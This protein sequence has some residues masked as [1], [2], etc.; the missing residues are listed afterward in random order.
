MTFEQFISRFELRR[1]TNSGFMVKCPAHDDSQKTPS[2]SVGKAKDGGVVLKC[3]AGCTTDS[4]VKSLGLSMK[5]L[6]AEEKAVAFNPPV[7][8]EKSELTTPAVKPTI[9]KIYSYRDRNGNEVYQALRLNPK[10]FRQRHKANGQWVWTMDNVERVLYNLPEVLKAE[11]VWIVEGEK[12]ADNLTAL[13]MVATCNV[14]GAGKWLDGYS[15]CLK[16]KHVIICGDNDEAGQRHVK[17]VSES[18]AEKAKSV[19]IIK[20]VGV[21]DAS[22][23]ISKFADKAEAKKAFD[24]M[25]SGSVPMIGGQSLPVFSMAD[26]EPLY[27]SQ[28]ALGE[29]VSLDLSKWLPSFR[30][31]RPVIQGE[32]VLIMGDTGTGKTAILQNIAMSNSHLKTLL[33]EMELP[34]E[35]LFERF[36]ALKMQYDCRTVWAEYNQNEI[37]GEKA[38]M[39]L[40]PNLFVCPQS[41]VSLDQLENIIMR[42]E[43]KMGERPVLVL[44]DYV[45]LIQGTGN[46]YEKTSNIAEGLKV[47]AKATRTIIVV[48]SQVNRQSGNESI[49][50][51]SAKDS[52]SLENSAG[53][54]IGAE[55]VF[56]ENNPDDRNHMRLTVLKATKGGGGT[57]INCSFDGGKML[58]T[59]RSNIPTDLS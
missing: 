49:G 11:T 33:F 26:I 20:P 17:L 5:D 37:M 6:F 3:F 23:Y 22:D 56:D 36:L 58:I 53:V 50:L 18:I 9:E 34:S 14:G 46:R 24:D 16:G 57:Q 15:E 32:L 40:F 41:R 31:V 51:H 45:Q 29:S 4:V 2:L 52:G 25:V 1:K 44:V 48:T 59:E 12:D 55:R 43:L 10:S 13:G 7:T 28:V 54:V 42:A 30:A 39:T 35:L 8:I 47:L 21:K 27:K 38:M 19:R